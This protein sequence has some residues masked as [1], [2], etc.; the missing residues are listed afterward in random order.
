MSNNVYVV[1]Q[2]YPLYVAWFA[3]YSARDERETLEDFARL[4]V[5][6][7]RVQES[8]NCEIHLVIAWEITPDTVPTPIVPDIGRDSGTPVYGL[9]KHEVR[10]EYLRVAEANHEWV[11]SYLAKSR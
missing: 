2:S 6:Q 4:T 7:M 9:E 1:T 11:R 8:R 3:R 10:E 5:Q